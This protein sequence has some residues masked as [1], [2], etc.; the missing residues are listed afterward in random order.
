MRLPFLSKVS[1]ELRKLSTKLVLDG[2]ET[3]AKP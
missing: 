3:I 2:D 1:R